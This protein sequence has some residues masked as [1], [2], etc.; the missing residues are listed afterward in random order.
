M[1]KVKICS[2]YVHFRKKEE[3]RTIFILCSPGCGRRFSVVSNLRRHNKVHQ[4]PAVSDK[5]SSEDRLRYVRQLI[6]SSNAILAKQKEAYDNQQHNLVNAV[7]QF[8]CYPKI[9]PSSTVSSH[10]EER[11][12]NEQRR[13]ANTSTSNRYHHYIL[14]PAININNLNNTR[15]ADSYAPVLT[16]CIPGSTYGGDYLNGSMMN[17]YYQHQQQPQLLEPNAFV[18]PVN[19]L[20][21]QEQEHGAQF[22]SYYSYV[23]D[24]TDVYDESSM[25]YYP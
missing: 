24:K 4:K 6:E 14:L 21:S 11:N 25:N 16:D 12:N 13:I 8:S 15:S 22:T 5:I 10:S 3:T 23:D 17:D 2:L 20:S 7:P 9:Y 1:F 19:H 18:S